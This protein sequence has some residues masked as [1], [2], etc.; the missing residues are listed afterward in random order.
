MTPIRNSTSAICAASR[1]DASQ[2]TSARLRLALLAVTLLA[3]LLR[4]LH[5]EWQPLWWDEGYSVFFATQPLAEM[6]SLTAQ[7]IHPPLYY[8]L[9]HF[10]TLLLDSARPAV[11]RLFSV[12]AGALAVP[13]LAVLAYALT[14]RAL[15]A[16]FTSVLL[17]INPLDVYYSQEVRMY[18][19]AL[20]LGLLSTYAMHRWLQAAENRRPQSLRLAAYVVS[21]AL[22]VHTLYYAA[23]LIAAQFIWLLWR[24][25][26]RAPDRRIILIAAG[27]L[28]LLCLPWIAYALPQL[29]HYIGDKVQSDQD[30]PVGPLTYI[31]RHLLAFTAGHV[32]FDGALF[33]ALAYLGLAAIIPL[34]FTTRVQRR[35]SSPQT[36]GSPGQI[37]ML[38]LFVSVPAVLAFL[39]NLRFPFFPQGGER[40]LLVILPYFLMLI[41][42]GIL[43]APPAR[44]IGPALAVALV[45]PALSG[46]TAYYAVPRY[47]DDDYRPVIAQVMQQGSDD[48]AVL[49]LFPWQVG[50]W[51]AYSPRSADGSLLSPQPE[52]VGQEALV[53]DGRMQARIDD[54]LA[55]GVLWFPA[56]VSF[57]S[58]LPGEIEDYLTQSAL[59]VE[60]RWHGPSTRLTAWTKRPPDMRLKPVVDNAV[61]PAPVNAA[62]DPAAV[63]AD[64]AVIAVALQWPE[65]IQAEAW[66]VVIRLMDDQGRE[67]AGRDYEPLGRFAASDTDAAQPVIDVFGLIVP[68]GLPPGDYRLAAGVV[69]ATGA[70]VVD[71]PAHMVTFG[72]LRVD[73]PATP[74]SIHRLPV[75]YPTRPSERPGALQ[76]RGAAN[77]GTD[78]PH[79]AGTYL[80]FSLALEKA[81]QTPPDTVLSVKLLDRSGAS[82]AGW[83]GW[84]LP[85]Y[86]PSLW[87]TQGLTLAPISLYLP[88]DMPTGRYALSASI[89]H[90]TQA[91]HGAPQ[92]LA[93][94]D[95]LVRPA[96]TTRPEPDHRLQTPVQFGTH[97][98]LYGYDLDADGEGLRLTLYWEALQTLLPPHH[99]FVHVNAPSGELVAQHDGAPVSA[100]GP[101][102]TGSWRAGEFIVSQHAVPLASP[103]DSGNGIVQAVL[104]VGLYEPKSQVRLPAF[105]DGQPAG[106]SAVI[107]VAP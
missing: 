101:A 69:A 53:W 81:D 63:A 6:L 28:A 90:G 4:V 16:V 27:L 14:R 84:P 9:L 104:Q 11:D 61:T 107:A 79:L 95:V 10:W 71:A 26:E 68:P 102:P 3:F 65:N 25:R 93:E 48:D 24:A 49:A 58:T 103:A 94:I 8:A 67:W 66:H 7:D 76:I 105:V 47:V 43:E 88:A 50:Y 41:T 89:S 36:L 62:I 98:I 96:I 72:Q 18:S 33:R 23:F 83:E 2:R 75:D 56:P 60:N 44:W 97:A 92:R 19:L 45:A 99:I 13:L 31:V 73:N 51:R 15:V 42:L 34:A 85:A 82:V 80:D 106:D 21:A 64:N 55:H 5:L 39:L 52:A 46:L 87:P 37:T 1:Q 38:W 17:A 32:Q 35:S 54:A 20:V 40:L 22:L 77:L 86:P 57:G 12:Y 30:T 78:Q 91:A 70:P 59:N 100:M 74:V 29:I